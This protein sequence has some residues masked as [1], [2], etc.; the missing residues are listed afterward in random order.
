MRLKP[1]FAAVC[2]LA[3]APDLAAAQ[4]VL[5]SRVV[6]CYSIELGRWEPT[7]ALGGD[8]DFLQ[9]PTRIELLAD[10]GTSS[11]ERGKWLIRP[12][13]GVAASRHRFSYFG[14]VG[15]DSIELVWTSGFSGLRMTV[16]LHSDTL[17][18]HAHALWDFDRQQQ[19]APAQVIRRPC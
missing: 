5:P 14:A 10:V 1:A 12:A 8:A 19:S 13:P 11:I 16:A 9:P 7:I 15:R 18:G 17:R 2:F 3:V 6:G 4:A